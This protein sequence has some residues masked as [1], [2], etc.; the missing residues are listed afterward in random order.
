MPICGSITLPG[1][2]SISHRAIMLAGLTD[3][4]CIIHNLS[5][6]RDVEST[7]IC[8]SN[9]G[10]KSRKENEVTYISGGEFENPISPLDCGNSGTTARLISGL[11]SGQGV[12]AKLI[13]DASLSARPMGRAILPLTE[14]G[15]E[16]SS[17]NGKLP[18]SIFS[19]E[20]NG[21]KYTLPVASAQV[22]SCIILAA[23]GAMSETKIIDS[24]KT[25]DHS[26]IILKSLGANILVDK[27]EILISPLNGKLNSFE[28]TVPGD[29]SSAAF[30]AAATAMIPNSDLIIKK[31][32]ANAT[33]IGFFNVLEKMGGGIEWKNLH[34]EC[35]E[36]VGDVHIYFQPL[37]GISL[38]KEDI[39]SIID[40]LPILAVLA[41]TAH[42][43][44]IIEGA[45]ELRIKETDRI[46][47]ICTNLLSM[48]VNVV[49]KK[50]G[51]IIDAP[52]ILQSTNIKSFGDH[53]IAMA[54]TIA[55]LSA[56][57]YNQI[58]DMDCVNISFPEFSETLKSIIK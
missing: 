46:H 25:R 4:E 1:D 8:L 9:C 34:R 11:L 6:G 49:E 22:K 40:E 3:G 13:G 45:G 41:S 39:P 47:A 33:R 55:G 31:I 7:R 48:G 2:K 53:R 58:D 21:I 29:P 42:G 17:T 16:I 12:T 43:P 52:N 54:F 35:G 57:S 15:A 28:L 32:S 19:R 5:T 18:L 36:L 30:F 26:E 56:G 27:N 24:F 23:L 44:T 37:H 50:D 14:M 20:L 51:F 10:I 38:K